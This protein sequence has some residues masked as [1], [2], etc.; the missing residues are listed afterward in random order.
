[1]LSI[2]EG[3][4]WEDKWRRY[5]S[6]LLQRVPGGGRKGSLRTSKDKLFF[7]LVYLKCYPTV[8]V[9]GFLFDM[10]GSNAD[11]WVHRL[12]PVL[13][14]ALDRKLVLPERKIRS[15]EEFFR[16]FPEASRLFID[17]TE[18]PILRPKDNERQNENYSGKK[19]GHTRKNLIICDERRFISYLS[20]TVSGK[21]HDYGI[22]KGEIPPDVF[23][24]GKPLYGDKGFEGIEKD[25]PRLHAIMP[26]KKPRGG[27]LTAEEK[28]E[29]RRINGTR[30]LVEHAISGVK[31]LNIMTDKFRNK[32]QGLIDQAVLLSCGLW[33]FH[34]NHT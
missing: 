28:E 20:P 1:M 7:I 14:K 13:E 23:P 22:F 19:K 18:R 25:Y 11:R 15:L 27:E 5:R 32:K 16:I 26:K 17:G 31:R 2:F 10:D 29:N 8:D 33:N 9:I 34:I 24:K 21:N 6:G 4:L 12:F 3:L 30:V